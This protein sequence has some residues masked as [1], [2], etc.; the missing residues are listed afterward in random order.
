MLPETQ[1]ARLSKAAEAKAMLSVT[2][3]EIKAQG[4]KKIREIYR[5]EEKLGGTIY[6]GN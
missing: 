2:I 1:A 5:R 3:K 4:T 6:N